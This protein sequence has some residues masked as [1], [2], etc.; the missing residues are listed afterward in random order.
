MLGTPNSA[1]FALAG[2]NVV[3]LVAYHANG[4]SGSNVFLYLATM[5]TL[6][7]LVAYML[8]SVGAISFLFIRNRIART[9]EIVIPIAAIVF[10]G[11]TLLKQ[12][13]PV[14]PAPT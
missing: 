11:Y 12:I 3:F 14:P 9:W 1:I 13:V 10:L 8:T 4:T 5:G 7:L 6:S 2:C